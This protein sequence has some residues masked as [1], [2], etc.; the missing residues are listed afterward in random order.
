MDVAVTG[1]RAPCCLWPLLA[2]VA[3]IVAAAVETDREKVHSAWRDIEAAIDARDAARFMT[4]VADDF[5]S[6][7]IDRAELDQLAKEASAELVDGRVN[8]RGFTIETLEAGKATTRFTASYEQ[9][10]QTSPW[11]DWQLTFAAGADGRWRLTGATCTAP[12][13]LDIKGAIRQLKMFKRQGG[14]LGV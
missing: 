6:D 2:I 9:G 7:R 1:T 10:R 13:D 3:A 11:T 8:V 12:R 5:S 14:D 4:H